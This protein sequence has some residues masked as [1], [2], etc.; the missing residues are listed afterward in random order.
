ML[1]CGVNICRLRGGSICQS[2]VLTAD[3]GGPSQLWAVIP[4]QVVLGYMRKLSEHGPVNSI[5]VC[6]LIKFMP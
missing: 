2:I 4:G 3:V 5:P 6:F 1:I